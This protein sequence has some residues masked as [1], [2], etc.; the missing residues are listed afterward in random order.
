MVLISE[1][2]PA[3][4]ARPGKPVSL[5]T[6]MPMAMVQIAVAAWCRQRRKCSV[7]CQPAVSAFGKIT[8]LLCTVS[9]SE[10]RCM[11]DVNNDPEKA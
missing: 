10:R 3:G 9:I 8:A 4:S 6:R 11:T 5:R 7:D 1:N 2:G